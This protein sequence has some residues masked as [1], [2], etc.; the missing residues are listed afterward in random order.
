MQATFWIDQSYGDRFVGY[1]QVNAQALEFPRSLAYDRQGYEIE[2]VPVALQRAT[3]E[4]AR[5]YLEDSTQFLADTAAG[6]NVVAD[7]ITVGPI[8]IN[9]TYGGGKDTAKKFVIV[10]RLFKVAGLIDNSIWADR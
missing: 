9:K 3:A 8:S 5:R 1:R 2:G 10:D 6:S 4:I 7:S